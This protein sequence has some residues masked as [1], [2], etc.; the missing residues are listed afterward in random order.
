[1][2]Q[3]FWCGLHASAVNAVLDH[4][5]SQRV[6]QR[7]WNR[8]TT[9]WSSDAQVQSAIHN[10]LGWLRIADVMAA[11]A[12]PLRTFTQEIRQAGFTHAL[13]LG[14]GGSGLFAEVCRNTFGAAPGHERKTS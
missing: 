11:Q 13:L 6:I 10:R 5:A 1:M 12:E 2:T 3:A 8:D 4:L 7:L 14:M 9:L